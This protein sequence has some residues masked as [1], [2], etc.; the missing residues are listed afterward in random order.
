MV[1]NINFKN[2]SIA[3]LSA[4]GKVSK[5]DNK[6]KRDRH[7]NFKRFLRKEEKEHQK[8]ENTRKDKQDAE[9]KKGLEDVVSDDA[10]QS[11]ASQFEKIVSAS[12]GKQVDVR[13]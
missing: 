7:Q 5:A 6:Q 11:P 1:D 3:P 8:K 9:P 10:D 12:H 4:A 2:S 13:V